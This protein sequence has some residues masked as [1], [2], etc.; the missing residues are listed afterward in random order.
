MYSSRRSVRG[1]LLSE[2]SSARWTAAERPAR[3]ESASH[4]QGGKA[5]TGSAG[6]S[7]S[8][9]GNGSTFATAATTELQ[10]PMRA[11]QASS[12]YVETRQLVETCNPA[13]SSLDLPQRDAVTTNDAQTK[14]SRFR[15]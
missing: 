8:N 5:A 1:G 4:P 7:Q 10:L 3:A 15:Q 14:R 9:G 11:A 6:R 13:N 12:D 2:A